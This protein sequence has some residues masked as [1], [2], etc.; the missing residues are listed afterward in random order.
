MR[1]T[2]ACTPCAPLTYVTAACVLLCDGAL[3]LC[4]HIPQSGGSA[5]AALQPGHSP[6]IPSSL[7]IPARCQAG[8][9]TSQARFMTPF[10]LPSGRTLLTWWMEWQD[11]RLH[12][13]PRGIKYGRH[14][15]GSLRKGRMEIGGQP[16]NH[17][18]CSTFAWR[19]SGSMHLVYLA[20]ARV[21]LNNGV[22]YLGHRKGQ[23][24]ARWGEKNDS[25][26]HV[27]LHW[28]KCPS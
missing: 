27:A 21:C 11:R 6:P 17:T 9:A 19:V 14:C 8:R 15:L 24:S 10:V 5:L 26:L 13:H 28:K 23:Q 1:S 18:W 12:S 25:L 22:L 2:L 4:Q 16:K 7:N 3:M 20:Q